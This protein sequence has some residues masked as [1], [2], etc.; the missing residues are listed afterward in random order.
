MHCSVSVHTEYYS[1]KNY[2]PCSNQLY[3]IFASGVSR[4]SFIHLQISFNSALSKAFRKE[5]H[6][7]GSI[8][9][10]NHWYN[11]DSSRSSLV[12]VFDLSSSRKFIETSSSLPIRFQLDETGLLSL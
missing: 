12:S 5:D 10:F 8:D 7:G 6:V 3:N 9:D 1:D 2:L 11:T 4:Y